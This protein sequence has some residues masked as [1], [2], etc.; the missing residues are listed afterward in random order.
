MTPQNATKPLSFTQLG[1]E[2]NRRK[3]IARA[4]AYY[5]FLEPLVKAGWSLE[6]IRKT[7]SVYPI[8]TPSGKGKWTRAMVARLIDRL[9][10]EHHRKLAR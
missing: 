10:L 9:G 6:E 4:G 1:A 2:A 5:W 7:L 3:A 8:Q